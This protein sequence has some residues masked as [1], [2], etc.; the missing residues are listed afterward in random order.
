MNID[1]ARERH[2]SMLLRDW[3]GEDPKYPLRKKVE[4]DEE[5]GEDGKESYLDDYSGKCIP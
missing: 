3:N 5:E 2:D 4:Q 1:L